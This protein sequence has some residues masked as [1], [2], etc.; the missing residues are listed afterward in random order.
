MNG[1][2]CNRMNDSDNLIQS[3]QSFLLH[4]IKNSKD[5]KGEHDERHYH[6]HSGA[7][8]GCQI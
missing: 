6:L 3:P 8:P 7:I 1:A 2:P 5:Q 4:E